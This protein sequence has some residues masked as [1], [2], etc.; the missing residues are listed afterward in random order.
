M[1]L[2][3]W[4][5]WIVWRSGMPPKGDPEQQFWWYLTLLMYLIINRYTQIVPGNESESPQQ[6]SLSATSAK[7]PIGYVWR[8][9]HQVDRHEYMRGC[10]THPEIS[11]QSHTMVFSKLHLGSDCSAAYCLPPSMFW[12]CLRSMRYL[13]EAPVW[14]LENAQALLAVTCCD[15][16]RSAVCRVLSKVVLGSDGWSMRTVNMVILL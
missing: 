1:Q 5:S 11:Y 8:I 2:L 9:D 4:R 16:W 7:H 14:G 12:H 10:S 6:A 13:F 15:S 3:V